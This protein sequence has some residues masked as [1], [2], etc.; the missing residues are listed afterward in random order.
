MGLWEH[1][2]ELESTK[3]GHQTEAIVIEGCGSCYTTKNQEGNER[4]KYIDLS[5]LFPSNLLWEPPIGQRQ[6]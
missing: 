3:G 5:L 1:S 4:N 2:Q 6:Q